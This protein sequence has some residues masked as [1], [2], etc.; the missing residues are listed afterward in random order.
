MIPITRTQVR[1]RPDPRRVVIRPFLPAPAS[2]PDG[3]ARARQV[4]ERILAL[5]EADMA[6]TLAATRDQFSDRH[7]DLDG[8][9]ERNYEAVA[10][11]IEDPGRLDREQ[12]LL[13]GAYFTHE[14][15]IEAAALSNPS[16][17]PAPD[18]S[19]LAAGELRFIVSLRAIGEGH[20]SSIEFRSGIIDSKGNVQRRRAEP[21]HDHGT[22]S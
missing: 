22:A 21:L 6:S 16:I 13:I 14:Y 10:G 4:I 11:L 9:L 17:V 20:L 15:S 18:Q 5:S 1:M 2:P 8:A 19:G 7:P 12:R 3:R